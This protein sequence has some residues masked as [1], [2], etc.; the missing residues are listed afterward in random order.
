MK[1]IRH[2]KLLKNKYVFTSLAFL[3]WM[4]FFDDANFI[5]QFKLKRELKKQK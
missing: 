3:V 4:T 1:H 5:S 2:L